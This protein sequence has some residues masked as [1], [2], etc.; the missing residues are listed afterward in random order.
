MFKFILGNIGYFAIMAFIVF[1]CAIVEGSLGGKILILGFVSCALGTP[2]AKVT[3]LGTVDKRYK[4]K[5][6]IWW[7]VLVGIILF[8]I[9]GFIV[10]S[11]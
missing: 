4:E 8:A 11:A 1:C 3:R 6:V 7:Q 10:K 5:P 2:A 9:G